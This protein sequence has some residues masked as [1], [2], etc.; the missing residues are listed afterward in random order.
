MGILPVQAGSLSHKSNQIAI[1]N[2]IKLYKIV[3]FI[4][5]HLCNSIFRIVCVA[6][7]FFKKKFGIKV[8]FLIQW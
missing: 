7:T 2:S 5:Y 6:R 8:L 4:M 1:C 3:F